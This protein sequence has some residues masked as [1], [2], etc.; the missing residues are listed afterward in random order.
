VPFEFDAER[1]RQASAHQEEWGRRLISELGLA[2]GE[3][4]LDLGCG[5]GRLTA[6][7]ADLVPR[8]S[9]LGIDASASMIEATRAHERENLE[10]I[11]LDIDDLDFQEEFDLLFSNAT[12]HWI[13]DHHRLLEHSIRALKP[14]GALRFNFAGDGNCAHF[15]RAVREVMGGE[16][17]RGYF[18]EFDWPWFMPAVEQYREIVAS[19]PLRDAR[20]W[21]ENADTFFPGE[22]ALIA[23]IDQPSIVPF[24]TCI[25]EADKQSFRAEVIERMVE[26]TRRE[27]GR[28]F[29][30][31]RR[32]N[33]YARKP[34]GF[35]TAPQ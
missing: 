23:W 17:Y 8:G 27:D 10:S 12:L 16:R 11:V 1:Y 34:T 28:C 2:G 14:G 22:E 19:F 33:L 13:R 35:R 32:V 4:V 3:R 24:L 9:V 7:L 5:D 6:Q 26:A 18:E 15:Y 30:T 21:G 20:V 29:E 25:H 31:F